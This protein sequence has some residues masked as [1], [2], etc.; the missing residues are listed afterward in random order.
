MQGP[1]DIL[2]DKPDRGPLMPN[3]WESSLEHLQS[4]RM[5]GVQ[6]GSVDENLI[7]RGLAVHQHVDKLGS[8]AAVKIAGQFH[9]ECVLGAMLKNMKVF[10]HAI[11]PFDYLSNESVPPHSAGQQ[12]VNY[13]G[14]WLNSQ[15]PL[16]VTWI[17]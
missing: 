10:C 14:N 9:V 12:R 7:K 13:F 11:P 16:H 5:N 4:K 17:R 15:I 6:L 3:L 2:S 1:A 8:R